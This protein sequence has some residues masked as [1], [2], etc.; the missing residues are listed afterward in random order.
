VDEHPGQQEQFGALGLPTMVVF[1]DGKEAAQVVV[2]Q[3]RR[4]L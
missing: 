1:R 2:A 3:P 4:S